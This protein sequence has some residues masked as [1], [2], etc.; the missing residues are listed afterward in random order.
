[1]LFNELKLL[2]IFIGDDIYWQKRLLFYIDR[3][4]ELNL[5]GL[6][7][8]SKL[9]TKIASNIEFLECIA[10]NF[11]NF[12]EIPENVVSNL[13]EIRIRLDLTF[14]YEQYLTKKITK[15]HYYQYILV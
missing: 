12:F 11:L 1:M 8:N 9:E 7:G 2:A 6:K 5:N 3:L 14:T 15:E 10:I 13:L 4:I